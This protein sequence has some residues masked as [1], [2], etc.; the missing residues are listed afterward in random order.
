[1]RLG[2]GLTRTKVQLTRRKN[3]ILDV[4]HDY[5]DRFLSHT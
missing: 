5:G 1:V 2:I 3:K 4:E